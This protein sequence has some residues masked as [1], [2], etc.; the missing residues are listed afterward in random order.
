MFEYALNH[1]FQMLFMNMVGEHAHE[2]VYMD[3]VSGAGFNFLVFGG[4]GVGFFSRCRRQLLVYSN[5][6][7]EQRGPLASQYGLI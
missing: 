3:D 7:K 1:P 4:L 5:M 6:N 2:Y